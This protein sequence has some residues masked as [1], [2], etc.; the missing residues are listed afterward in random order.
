MSLSKK[1]LVPGLLA[2]LISPGVMAYEMVRF[3]GADVVQTETLITYANGDETYEFTGT[4]IRLGLEHRD[5]G[6]AGIEMISG[7]S[8]DI[9][10]PF[11]NPFRLETDI[12]IGF[13]EG[14]GGA[15]HRVP[16]DPRNSP[17]SRGPVHASAQQWCRP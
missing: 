4:R 8:D 6:S 13:Y 11:G 12:S 7:D 2:L 16:A 9:I 10:D 14:G 17:E 15:G 5:G 3:I 1:M